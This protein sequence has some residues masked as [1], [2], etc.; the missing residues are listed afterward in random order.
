M[1]NHLPVGAILQQLLWNNIHYARFTGSP[2]LY[3]TMET[4]HKKLECS[5][6]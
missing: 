4:S 5:W 3:V 1:R 6:A 2:S